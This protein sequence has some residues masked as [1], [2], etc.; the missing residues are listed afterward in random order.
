MCYVRKKDLAG[1][2]VEW[3][4]KAVVRK[5]EFLVVSKAHKAVF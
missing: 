3:I 2:E 4:K 1:N 5:A